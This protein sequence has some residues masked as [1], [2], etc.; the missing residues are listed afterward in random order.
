MVDI[1]PFPTGLLNY[2]AD[3]PDQPRPTPRPRLP[4]YRRIDYYRPTQAQGTNTMADRA[5]VPTCALQEEACP[6]DPARSCHCSCRRRGIRAAGRRAGGHAQGPSFLGADGDAA[7]DAADAVVRQDREGLE[8]PD[9]MPDLS[10]D[11]ARRRAAAAHPAGDG[12]RRRHRLDAS[13]LHGRPLSDHGSV[14][15]AVHVAERRSDEPGGVGLLHA[16]RLQG[17]PRD[18][19]AR[20]QR[21]R[22]RLHPHRRASRSR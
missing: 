11:A 16:V 2:W 1:F 14:R 10:G 22:Q 21:A 4:R 6:I 9:E 13:R 17:I 19:G 20:R 15:A 3:A 5:A 7:V 8:Q 12:R 18:Q